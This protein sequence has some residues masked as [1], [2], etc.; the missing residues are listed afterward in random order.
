MNTPL[1]LQA[2]VQLPMPQGIDWSRY[3]Q[4][5][6]MRFFGNLVPPSAPLPT[7]ATKGAEQAA[8]SNIRQQSSAGDQSG[9]N[10]GGAPGGSVTNPFGTG[11]YNS[12]TLASLVGG[13]LP[14]PGL[15]LASGL[16]GTAYDVSRVNSDLNSIGLKGDLGFGRA[17]LGNATFGLLGE[18]PQ[19]YFDLMT[20]GVPFSTLQQIAGVPVTAPIPQMAAPPPVQ[21]TGSASQDFFGAINDLNN[22]GRLGDVLAEQDAS[23]AGGAGTNGTAEI[24]TD[25]GG[26]DAEAGRGSEWRDGGPVGK[27]QTAKTTKPV[28]GTVH[29]GEFVMRP[30]ARSAAGDKVM[31]AINDGKIPPQ[32]LRAL[33]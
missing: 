23:R 30:E 33:V 24:N 20:A 27:P 17:A 21:T 16:A 29:T 18:T 32:K 1:N 25:P 26:V 3:G 5:P 6:A 4:N 19:A 9:E 15:G 12:S 14:V 13:A 10:R 11:S 7:E 31:H 28:K 8:A 22:V 2:Q